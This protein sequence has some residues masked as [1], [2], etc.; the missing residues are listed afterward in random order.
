M[1]EDKRVIITEQL[2]KNIYDL[3]GCLQR[4]E[5]SLG[6]YLII[7]MLLKNLEGLHQIAVELK[8]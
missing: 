5:I 7:A 8:K 4:K 2:N 3:D 1:S 6:E